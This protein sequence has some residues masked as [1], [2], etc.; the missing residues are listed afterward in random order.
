MQVRWVFWPRIHSIFS[1]VPEQVFAILGTSKYIFYMLHF[2]QLVS[3]VCM[4][5]KRN[6]S[7]WKNIMEHTE[8]W[9]FSN[10]RKIYIV[11][12]LKFDFLFRSLSLFRRFLLP[13]TNHPG[14]GT[15]WAGDC[16]R[17]RSTG[18]KL[19]EKKNIKAKK[20]FSSWN[21]KTNI[22]SILSPPPK[23]SF[24]DVTKSLIKGELTEFV[25]PRM[26]CGQ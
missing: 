26:F 12:K 10:S 20:Y 15:G 1:Q 14:R 22:F 5:K 23:S 6:G 11:T 9:R 19:D 2:T 16:R 4:E 7:F 8:Y 13:P 21:K 17:I 3:N 24:H 18:R 25:D